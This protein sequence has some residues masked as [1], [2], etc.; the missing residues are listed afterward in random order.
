[1]RVSEYGQVTDKTFDSI[2]FHDSRK[3]PPKTSTSSEDF[4]FIEVRRQ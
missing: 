4:F 1:M 3:L 2:S